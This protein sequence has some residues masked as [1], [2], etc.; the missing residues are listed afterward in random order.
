MAVEVASVPIDEKSR[1]SGSPAPS[2]KYVLVAFEDEHRLYRE[3]VTRIVCDL[4]PHLEAQVSEPD[5][6]RAAIAR[7]DPILVICNRP[8]TVSPNGR[9]AWFELRNEPEGF[10]LLC[11]DGKYSQKPNPAL[12]ELL[13]AIDAA[14][15]LAR[16]KEELGN[17]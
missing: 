9:P 3:V 1:R 17:C 14:E 8:N 7:L 10:G 13:R 6:I 12:D 16:T 15:E 4:R 2:R 5:A 11:I